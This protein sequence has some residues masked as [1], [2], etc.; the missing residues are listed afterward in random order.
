MASIMVTDMAMV[1]KRENE[2]LINYNLF[3]VK[4]SRKGL[5]Y[6]CFRRMD[7]IKSCFEDMA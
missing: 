6:W 4:E 2:Y 5:F 3:T 7:Y 1:K